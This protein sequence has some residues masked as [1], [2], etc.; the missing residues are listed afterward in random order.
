MRPPF[1]IK[2]V[3]R[4][5]YRFL[6]E[7]GLVADPRDIRRFTEAHVR[8]DAGDPVLGAFR[9]YDIPV[10]V[11]TSVTQG[12]L[13]LGG[14]ATLAPIAMRT[15][16]VELDVV[17]EVGLTPG[18]ADASHNTFVGCFIGVGDDAAFVALHREGADRYLTV[19]DPDGGGADFEMPVVV[20]RSGT[21]DLTDMTVSQDAVS[22]TSPL[23]WGTH[24]LLRLRRKA[25]MIKSWVSMDRGHS[26]NAVGSDT[27]IDDE[28]EAVLGLC[29]SDSEGAASRFYGVKFLNPASD[30]GLD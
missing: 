26:W 7:E 2:D 10:S 9:P 17:C 18:L 16:S 30:V 19:H 13:R 22:A 29:I 23:I 20:A 3:A 15:G 28:T 6:D 8:A 25:T 14:V 1:P 4:L 27:F 12:V 11:I 24:A 5:S 21:I